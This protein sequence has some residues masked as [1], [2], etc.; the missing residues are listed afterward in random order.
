MID[1]LVQRVGA[2]FP[3]SMCQKVQRVFITGCGDSHHAALNAQLAM[4]QLAGLPCESLT[5]M[6]FSRYTAGFLP[7][8]GR[9]SN[10]LLGVSVSGQVSR[11]IEA[12]NLGRKAGATTVAV[13]GNRKAPLANVADLVL[14][15]SVPSLPAELAG[16]IVP[17]SRSYVASQ[18][19]LYLL[20]VH[21][22]HTRG[23]ISQSKANNLRREL[24]TMAG[25][26]EETIAA[27][28][29]LTR[30]AAIFWQ[31][32]NSFVYCGSGPNFGTALFSAAKVLE[33]SG[34]SA[35]AQDMEEWA[36][37]QYFAR[38]ATTPTLLI[39]AGDRDEDRTLEIAAAAKT[40]GRQLAIIA[41][42]ESALAK[43]ADADYLFPLA[44]ATRE[45][46]S[47]MLACLPGIIFAA[48]RAQLTS[49]PYF[50]AFGGGRSVEGGGG[51]SRI[52][53]SHR[54]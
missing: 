28:D 22:G 49:E 37:L 54:R 40:I 21:L 41:P 15:T 30:Q 4:Q 34:D 11:T 8:T 24:G 45:C 10:L 25:L 3:K 50:R 46:F 17:G 5:A 31:D 13:T 48:Y 6:Q 29:A 32:E 7:D 36:H 16:L 19:V 53:D 1:D 2:K 35:L 9:G 47:P 20:A 42:R 23:H 43:T 14:Q 39:S 26:M 51:V 18:L 33:A 12:L 44:A 38:H 52:R 27:C